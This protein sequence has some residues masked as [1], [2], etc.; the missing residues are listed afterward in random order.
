[1]RFF[2]TNSAAKP[3]FVSAKE[4]ITHGLAPD[5]GLYMPEHIPSLP[6]GVLDLLEKKSIREIALEV[7]ALFLESEIPRSDLKN[8]VEDSIHFDAPLSM[9]DERLG[10]LELFHGPTSAFKDFGARFMSRTMAYFRRNENAPLTILVATSGDTGGAVA[11]GYHGVEGIR[12]VILYPSGKVS[13]L[14]EKQLT[15]FSGNV[16]AIEVAGSFD[17][18]Q[19]L[20]KEAFTDSDLRATLEL[21]SANSINIA[22]L[23]PQT[24]YYFSAC[25]QLR[26][27]GILESPVFS[28][29]SGNFG[30]LTAG[31]LA[32]RMGLGVECFI[33]ANNDNKPV[34]EYLRGEDFRAVPSVQ[35]ISNAMDVGNPSNFARL[36]SLFNE[37]RDAM[38]TRL[39]P[40]SV[41]DTRTAEAIA[42]CFRERNYI[43]DPHTAVGVLGL[44]DYRR[45]TQ[46]SAP[47]V[48][49]GT[50]HPA[51]FS[52][53]V[54]PSI[55]Q[56]IPLPPQLQAVLHREKKAVALKAEL[57]RLKSYLL[58][59][60]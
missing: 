56:N 18:C 22:R 19:R 17:D 2:S 21:S 36:L 59:T 45:D 51:K 10:V 26:S 30:N 57:S 43:L 7:S 58:E 35:T 50:A 33:A 27:R 48:V 8:I 55:G 31:I 6:S 24:F 20:V 44:E 40:F 47:G 1:M 23:I 9:I 54:E 42:S 12:V 46:S 3:S 29:P 11:S 13:P 32:E 53:I 15:T 41:D 28:V 5:G 4:A 14:Q 52:E 37:D 39:Y 60:R 38:R 34:A 49:L 25:A 16:E